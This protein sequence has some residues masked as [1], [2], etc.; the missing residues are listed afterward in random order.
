MHK[1]N[2]EE[3]KLKYGTV[4]FHFGATKSK[5]KAIKMYPNVTLSKVDP[6]RIFE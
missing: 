6:Y 3:R 5:T 4:L 2:F 1:P